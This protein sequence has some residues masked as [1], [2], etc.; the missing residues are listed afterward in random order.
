ME[1]LFVDEAAA[2][3]EP[4]VMIP[5][6]LRPQRMLAVGDPMQL[7]AT[8]TSRYAIDCGLDN[9]LIGRLMYDCSHEY[10]M[11]D[12]QYRMHPEIRSL[13]SKIFYDGKIRDGD[14]VSR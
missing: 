7:P 1:D 12:K 9:S 13:P 2:A 10:T 5:F 8:L 6:H 4:E 14:N 3:T 11:L